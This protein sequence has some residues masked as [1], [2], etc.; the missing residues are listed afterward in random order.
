MMSDKQGQ[1]DS[2]DWIKEGA[3]DDPAADTADVS[4]D[5]VLEGSLGIA[6]AEAMHQIFSTLL[7]A[8][9]DITIESDDLSRVDAAGA[10]LIY[11]FVKEAKSRSITVT[12]KS[13]SDTLLETFSILGLSDAMGFV[14]ADG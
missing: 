10:Q 14:A 3:A 5:L 1:T 13:V 7:D 9:I 8:H 11:A 6:E 12:W 2:L 4:G